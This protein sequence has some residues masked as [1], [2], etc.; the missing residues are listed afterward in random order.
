MATIAYAGA[1]LPGS[2]LV[3][4]LAADYEGEA[5]PHPDPHHSTEFSWGY[6][7]SGPAELAR[8]LLAHALGVP[9]ADVDPGMYQGFKRA[10]VAYW[11]DAW[12]ID[13]AEVL[14]WVE[15]YRLLE[16][17]EAGL[18]QDAW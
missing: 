7:G 4:V 13:H 9:A 8:C 1:R 17:L 15:G 11:G 18:G 14:R 6:H 16:S 12:R 2:H 10:H 5:L 3:H